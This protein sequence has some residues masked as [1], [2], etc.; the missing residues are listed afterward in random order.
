MK[1][2]QPKSFPRHCETLTGRSR[3]VTHLM[4]HKR[5][6]P[7]DRYRTKDRL[8]KLSV[9]NDS[10][11]TLDSPIQINRIAI[12]ST[13]GWILSYIA[14]W[15]SVWLQIW[16]SSVQQWHV[17]CHVALNY[18]NGL[19]SCKVTFQLRIEELA[20]IKLLH[21]VWWCHFLIFSI[22]PK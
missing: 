22:F 21:W 8:T 6:H 11:V 20:V 16:R 13:T 9:L 12:Y 10:N 15:K 18:N 19:H 5:K 3:A 2:C 7:K 17:Q 4:E 14:Q 1:L